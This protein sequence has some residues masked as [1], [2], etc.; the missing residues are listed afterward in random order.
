LKNTWWNK[1]EDFDVL[2]L[3]RICF[4]EKLIVEMVI[5]ETNMTLHKPMDLQE[6]YVWLGCIFFMSR[7]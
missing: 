3:F 4:P 1:I 7:F 6:F 2:A 5:P